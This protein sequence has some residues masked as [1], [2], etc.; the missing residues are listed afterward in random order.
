MPTKLTL[1]DRENFMAKNYDKNTEA[2]NK[3]IFGLVAERVTQRHVHAFAALYLDAVVDAVDRY[4]VNTYYEKGFFLMKERV[5]RNKF[6]LSDRF[7]SIYHARD[8]FPQ[9][10]KD[11]RIATFKVLKTETGFAI[12]AVDDKGKSQAAMPL[13]TSDD[14][15]K[16]GLSATLEPLRAYIDSYVYSMPD[17]KPKQSYRGQAQGRFNSDPFA[18]DVK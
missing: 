16:K 12:Y 9:I 18:K 17:V 4:L 15:M 2:G 6:N 7:Y 3:L 1:S 5:I 8:T 11:P 10:D 13:V 14:L